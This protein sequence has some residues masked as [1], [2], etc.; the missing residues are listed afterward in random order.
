[1]FDQRQLEDIN[2]QFGDLSESIKEI[3]E[4]TQDL[5]GHF[6]EVS[7]RV[8]S[9]V[10]NVVSDSESN[11][12][13]NNIIETT[14]LH[15]RIVKLFEGLEDK[16]GGLDSLEGVVNDLGEK[17]SEFSADIPG[18]EIKGP[19][20]LKK[21]DDNKKSKL[22]RFFISEA[23]RGISPVRS[24]ASKAKVP[25]IGGF[26]GGLIALMTYGF[27]DAQRVKAEAG[28]LKNILIAAT[29]GTMKGILNSAT[30]YSSGVQEKL[31]RFY[32][33]NRKEVQGVLQ[34]FVDGG[35]KISDMTRQVS[36]DIKGVKDTAL[37]A[38]LAIDKFLEVPGGTSAKKA[39]QSMAN[40]GKSFEEATESVMKLVSA[41]RESGI[42]IQQFMK[43]IESTSES[44]AKMGFD[45]DTVVDLA[46]NLQNHF[47][48]MGVPKQY[49][50]RQ[51]VL[52]LQQLAG[53]MAKMSDGWRMLI[54]ERMGYGTGIKGRQ[55]FMES[56][57]RVIRGNQREEQ[58]KMIKDMTEIALEASDNDESR[59]KY[60]LE[61]S[62]GLGFEGAN[63]AMEITKFIKDG[64]M[65]KAAEKLDETKELFKDSIETEKQKANQFQLLFN[66]WLKGMAKVGQ[67]LLGMVMD[68]LAVIVAYVRSIPE[69][70]MNFFSGESEKNL[71]ILR[72]IQGFFS[73]D[74]K[75]L[76][77]E[78]LDMAAE[79]FKKM[80]MEVLG[81]SLGNLRR[82]LSFGAEDDRPQYDLEKDLSKGQVN[83][84]MVPYK[85]SSGEVSYE[86][87]TL[88]MARRASDEDV[89]YQGMWGQSVPGKAPAIEL[90]SDGVD[91]DGNIHLSTVSTAVPLSERVSPFAG[92]DYSPTE[93]DVTALARTMASETG[94]GVKGH[95]GQAVT[96]E[97]AAVGWT[98]LN[99]LRDR[100][101]KGRGRKGGMKSVVT[102]G[103]DYGTLK[104][105]SG[106]V[107]RPYHTA[108][109]AN[110]SAMNLARRVLSGG[111]KDI[112][113]G[114]RFFWHA[115]VDPET[116][117]PKKI[118]SVMAKNKGKYK[119]RV[120]LPSTKKNRRFFAY[121]V[122]EKG[123]G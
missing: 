85:D 70:F 86:P 118:G 96:E 31:Q 114:S 90:V 80:G 68:S 27:K 26:I 4:N 104:T 3:S 113:G 10:S 16:L 116:K 101:S 45:I 103:G 97:A 57:S 88:A 2:K 20:E 38:F 64:N 23:K 106:K 63:A 95:T 62:V 52:G 65:T 11:T 99:R 84:V 98:A 14:H 29:D 37:T 13:K 117:K 122:K 47:E 17:L 81:E 83:Y 5:F 89:M 6:G 21:K 75:N 41:G 71:A 61:K 50:G 35:I 54:A 30:Q 108:R 77:G 58:L 18:K 82:A 43:N 111:F 120:S 42:G 73:S 66:E 121:D 48:E 67:G 51:A 79:S 28:E 110:E 46:V 115:D 92:L 100:L 76:M 19:F 40:Y 56:W 78:G 102:G 9:V 94:Y 36:I 7:S 12:L 53:G 34:A 33:I 91:E 112:T 55:K 8:A 24:M 32:G 60:V 1:M 69:L 119:V 39:I 87:E 123:Q 93:E 107:T 109:N 105:D 15:E 59:A 49:A 72:D 22:E 25:M 44:L 74:N